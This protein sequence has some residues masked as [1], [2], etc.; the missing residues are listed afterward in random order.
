MII[1]TL[2]WFN[3]RSDVVWEYEKKKNR[4]VAISQEHVDKLEN[5]YS[6]FEDESEDEKEPMKFPVM[7]D[8]DSGVTTLLILQLSLISSCVLG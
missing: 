8:E 6:K 7:V 2:T 3:H 5:F 1:F 4:W